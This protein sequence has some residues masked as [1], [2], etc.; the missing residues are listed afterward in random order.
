MFGYDREVGLSTYLIGKYNEDDIIEGSDIEN[1]DFINELYNKKE[2][3][4]LSVLLNDVRSSG[5]Y[6]YGYYKYGYGYDSNNG[7][8]GEEE[9]RSYYKRIKQ[10]LKF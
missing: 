8:Y 1:L 10:I 4:N 5:Y 7:Y 2:I 6:G 3:K 9:K